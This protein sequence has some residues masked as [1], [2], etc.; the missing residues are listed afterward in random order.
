M[1]EKKLEIGAWN[2][3]EYRVYT[4]L[5]TWETFFTEESVI[6]YIN[7]NDYCSIEKTCRAEVI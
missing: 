4:G 6:K 3:V 2:V 7:E 5:N 1:S